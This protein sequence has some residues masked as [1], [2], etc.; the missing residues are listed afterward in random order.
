MF[1][2]SWYDCYIFQ[3]TTKLILLDNFSY[4]KLSCFMH[5]I[6]HTSLLIKRFTWNCSH[7]YFRCIIMSLLMMKKGGKV[8]KRSFWFFL[9]FELLYEMFECQNVNWMIDLSDRRKKV[10]LYLVMCGSHFLLSTVTCL[11]QT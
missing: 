11:N 7:Y 5:T 10:S 4:P 1:I 6:E 2:C 3:L 9:G 8:Q